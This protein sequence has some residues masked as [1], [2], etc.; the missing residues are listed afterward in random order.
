M[1]ELGLKKQAKALQA[2]KEVGRANLLQACGAKV[3]AVLCMPLM[4]PFPS[5]GHLQAQVDVALIVL[6]PAKKV[7]RDSDALEDRVVPQSLRLLSS[8][9]QEIASRGRR[10]MLVSGGWLL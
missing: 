8:L 1:G 5:W 9:V 3:L 2:L 4:F 10:A 7:S 6:D